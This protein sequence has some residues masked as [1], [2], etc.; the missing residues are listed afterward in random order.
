MERGFIRVGGVVL[1]KKAKYV[2][3]KYEKK[4]EEEK[5]EK[6]HEEK[7]EEL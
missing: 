3:E 6:E 1:K 5:Y 4:H 2:N 7:N